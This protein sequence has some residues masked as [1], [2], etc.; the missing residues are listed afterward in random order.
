[1]LIENTTF[2]RLGSQYLI[3]RYRIFI[4]A[5]NICFRPADQIIRLSFH[6]Y[7]RY[8]KLILGIVN[9]NEYVMY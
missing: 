4:A 7:D 9:E 1:M 6:A 8:F 5:Q 2:F 3:Y